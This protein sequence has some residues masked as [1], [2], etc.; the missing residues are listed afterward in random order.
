MATARKDYRNNKSQLAF[1]EIEFSPSLSHTH[2]RTHRA[3]A[4]T[5]TG[6]RSHPSPPWNRFM[7]S[8]LTAFADQLWRAVSPPTS[9]QPE[10]V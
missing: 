2:T 5:E 8:L 6:D 3:C 9:L 1:S 4:L 7:V 10:V